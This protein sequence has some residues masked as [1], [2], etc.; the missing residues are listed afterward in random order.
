MRKLYTEGETDALR[1]VPFSCPMP[2]EVAPLLE[3]YQAAVGVLHTVCCGD[4][5]SCL[6]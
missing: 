3:R 2:E 6:L 5:R 1:R 4:I